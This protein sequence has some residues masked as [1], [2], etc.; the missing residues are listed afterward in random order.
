MNFMSS[1]EIINFRSIHL[2]SPNLP[3]TLFTHSSFIG[4]ALCDE[5]LLDYFCPNTFFLVLLYR[6]NDKKLEFNTLVSYIVLQYE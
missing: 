1:K 5:A 4:I 6:C 3:T 2:F